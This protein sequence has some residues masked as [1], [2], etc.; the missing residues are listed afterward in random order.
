MRGDE[1]PRPFGALPGAAPDC[2]AMASTDAH[3]PALEVRGLVQGF[4]SGFWMRER[5][6]LHGVDLR[7][8][9]G[10]FLGLVGPNG[11]GKSTLLRIL[12]AVDEARSGAVRVHGHDI[13]SAQA[14]ARLGFV[15]EDSPY[16]PELSARATLELCGAFQRLDRATRRERAREGLERVG[17]TAAAE[18]RLATFSRGMLRRLGLAA[19]LLHEPS[20][21]LLDEPTA[22]LDAEGFDVFLEALDQLRARGATLIV[23]SHLLTDLQRRCDRLAV[24]LDGRI[25][26]LAPPLE[27]VRSLGERAR[28]DMTLQGAEARTLEELRARAEA[29]GATVCGLEPSQSNLL[30]LYRSLRSERPT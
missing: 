24:M 20:V 27:L 30:E 2:R 28:I 26:A 6:V 29:L 14:R 3:S 17:L 8:E 23:S 7:L 25:V 1:H 5:T 19:A 13:S 22:G 4:A 10:E 11:S 21:L 16:P 18:R 12:A 15:P 9:P